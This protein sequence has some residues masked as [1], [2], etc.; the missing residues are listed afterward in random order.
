M[1]CFLSRPTSK[2]ST[3][4]TLEPTPLSS[5][6][7]PDPT[8]RKR[9]QA[10]KR[11]QLKQQEEVLMSGGITVGEVANPQYHQA[12]GGGGGEVNGKTTEAGLGK[13]GI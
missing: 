8:E 12:G 13:G 6:R 2:Q 11:E 10:A 9:K 5:F 7:V 4:S 1:G 3:R